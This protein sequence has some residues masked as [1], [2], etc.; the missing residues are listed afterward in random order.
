[1]NSK[2]L[3]TNETSNEL[4]VALIQMQSFVA[5]NLLFEN[6]LLSSK[7]PEQ[8]ELKRCWIMLKYT[9]IQRLITT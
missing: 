7:I 8:I 4:A 6:L 2:F 9:Y 5:R 1:M 3:T